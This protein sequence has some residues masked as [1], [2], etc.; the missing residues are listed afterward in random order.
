MSTFLFEKC[1]FFYKW[2]FSDQRPHFWQFFLFFFFFFFFFFFEDYLF[3]DKYPLFTSPSFLTSSS[4]IYNN[5]TGRV[6]YQWRKTGQN[7]RSIWEGCTKT[8]TMKSFN[9]YSLHSYSIY[10][11]CLMLDVIATD[12]PLVKRSWFFTSEINRRQSGF[13][14]FTRHSRL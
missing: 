11:L 2:V 10:V 14:K 12:V 6:V 7:I 13:L 4:T 3:F 8:G 5:G 1:L 9:N